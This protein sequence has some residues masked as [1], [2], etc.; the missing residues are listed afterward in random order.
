M[1]LM[2]QGAAMLSRINPDVLQD[3]D[4][5]I[6]LQAWNA[7]KM[8]RAAIETQ[9]TAYLETMRDREKMQCIINK[10]ER[11]VHAEGKIMDERRK[12]LH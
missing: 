5:F 4:D 12:H 9:V 8:N 3:I 6:M 1:N 11:D 7:N 10:E 2:V